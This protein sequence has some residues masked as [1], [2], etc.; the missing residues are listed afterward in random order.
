MF[1]SESN[2]SLF[3]E[4][5]ATQNRL[6]TQDRSITCDDKKLCVTM[7]NTSEMTQSLRCTKEPAETLS[8]TLTSQ[9]GVSN[10]PI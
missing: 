8:I 10:G 1:S 3:S 7:A 4:S 6:S 2:D 9:G 5:I